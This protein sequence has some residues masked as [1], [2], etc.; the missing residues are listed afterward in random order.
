[1]KVFPQDFKQVDGIWVPSEGADNIAYTDGK[2][3]EDYLKK[4]IDNASDLSSTSTELQGLIRDWS[5]RYHL[6][7]TRGN[8]FRAL[9]MRP[10]SSILEL[11][12]GCGA[13]T[14]CLGENDVSVTAIEGSHQRAQI[15]KSRCR[16]L[17]NVE[18]V[19]SNFDDLAFENKFDIV[20][21]IGVLE[22]SHMFCRGQDD[23]F[24][25]VLNRAWNHLDDD[26]VLVIAIENQLGIK[27][28]SGCG[29]DHLGDRFCGIE[30]YPDDKGARTF[31]KHELVDLVESCGFVDHELLLP[32]PDY[33]LPS[34]LINAK[35][36]GAK[37]AKH[38]N[39]AG[40]CDQPY[41]DY[42]NPREHL[43]H[44][45]LGLDTMAANGL[46]A[47]HANS[48]LLIASKKTLSEASPIS[49]INWHAK[50]INVTRIPK[51]QTE[52]T[53]QSDGDEFAVF[54][55]GM[56]DS[57]ERSEN[58]VTLVAE[59]K[60]Q[61]VSGGRSLSMELTRSLRRT[62]RDVS[63]YQELIAEWTQY[64]LDSSASSAQLGE[65]P[66]HFVD[67]I[68]QNLIRDK[69]GKLVYIDTEWHWR[70]A[71][72][73]EWVV[74]RGLWVLWGTNKLWMERAF[75]KNSYTFKQFIDLSL[76][77]STLDIVEAQ[78]EILAQLEA[79][80]QSAVFGNEMLPYFK[81]LIEKTFGGEG[82]ATKLTMD[83]AYQKWINNHAVQE[84]DGQLFAERMMLKWKSRPKFH[85]MMLVFPGEETLLANT[86]DSLSQQMYP[87]WQLTVIADT[88]APDALWKQMDGLEWLQ[89]DK[90]GDP[91]N[92]LNEQIEHSDS[93]WV[94]YIEPGSTFEPQ[95]LVQLGDYI[96]IRPHWKL[97]YSDEDVMSKSGLRSDPKFKPDFNL[98]MLRSTPYVGNFCV[99]EKEAFI[100]VAGVLP[101]ITAENYDLTFKV[102]D[103]YGEHSIGHIC[104]VLYHA[105]A[106]PLRNYDA[107]LGMAVVRHHLERN[108][109]SAEVKEGYIP[110][111]TRIAYDF[112]DQ[113]VVSIII[114]NRDKLEYLQ[115]CIESLVDKTDYK[116]YEV[117]I[118]DNNSVDPDTLKYYQM[119]T[120]TYKETIKVISCG[121]TNNFS[122]LCNFGAKN[123]NGEFLL[124]L[125]SDTKM[126]HSEWLSRMMKHVQR[127]DIGVVGAR[128][129]YPETGKILHAGVVLGL[130][131]YAE[132]PF[133]G[134]DFKDPGYMG[135][136]QVDQ[137]YSAVSSVCLLTKRNVFELVNG[138][139]EA[140]FPAYFNGVDLCLKASEAGYKTLWTPY[141]TLVSHGGKG[142]KFVSR[143]VEGKAEELSKINL[144]KSA[145]LEKWGHKLSNDPAYNPNLSL[146]LQSF[147]VE[148]E[149]PLNWDTNFN[150]RQ[151]ILGFPLSGG[152]G[153]Y[154]V[155]QPFNAVSF[156]GLAQCEHYTKSRVNI[157]EVMRM[158]PNVTV[159]QA[160]IDDRQ[161]K[162]LEDLNRY[163][164]DVFRVFTLDDLITII[165]EKSS[166]YKSQK[167]SFPDARARLRKSL[168]LCQ[169]LIVTSQP[170]ADY[171]SDLIDDI[172]VIPNR[173]Q[174]DKWL[175]LPS[176]RGQGDKPRVG[177]VGAQQ[178]QGDLEII[179]DV[180]KETVDEVDWV[181]MG[182]CPEE[183][184]PLV[185]EYH[186]FVSIDEYPAKMASLNL[187]LAIAP[188]E[189]HEF[190]ESKSNLRLLEY[191]VFGWP[192]VCSD[193][194]PYQ[195]YDAPVTRVSNE[196]SAW[197]DAIRSHIRD[198]EASKLAG[199]ELKNWVLANFITEDHLEE[200]LDALTPAGIDLTNDKFLSTMAQ[201]A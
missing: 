87:D 176:Y 44:D 76:E 71:V 147:G 21:L 16:D 51:F 9:S 167:R 11:G 93:D 145:L 101:Y 174:R 82:E 20:T 105:P 27:Y 139:S 59:P 122:S 168:A 2:R 3:A 151:K 32:F 67:C 63:R 23:P 109:I 117:V 192:V 100:Q 128:V 14:R 94:S 159:V 164:P 64:L 155:V 126:L 6:S 39:L 136:A 89:F 150:D 95:T 22:Y 36:C 50:K 43:F 79:Q 157:V 97:I 116:N 5:S 148:V 200:W 62:D 186:E 172:R 142:H 198:P 115:P 38:L 4:S 12:S 61:H 152:S 140:Q 104:D 169:R 65:L 163:T 160:A 28:L 78:M 86:L 112:E 57:E 52:T 107:E 153:D 177:W 18:V 34:T 180:V 138:M 42:V 47:D 83:E 53:L 92:Q 120:S 40:W 191:G 124:F 195:S 184:R 13:I 162:L 48:F 118:V 33:K 81:S 129:V 170:L 188:L 173:L 113:P 114:P 15:S 131:G 74:F 197:L 96:N 199:I 56:V 183:I 45:H 108:K 134:V 30:G 99:V 98:D 103:Q 75:L 26:G 149:M 121:T 171:C 41:E 25:W 72:A 10:G 193:I 60:A 201:S 58:G 77:K 161:I 154:R 166:V 182:M 175:N 8:L 187:D 17:E 88:P 135:R 130:D 189:Q 141:S 91:Y 165:P 85:L 68:P 106:E 35:S 70:E 127:D 31:G 111:T 90:D 194:A 1:M 46:L 132:S 37:L 80:F 146:A 178:H 190:N 73:I 196:K 55:K 185:A 84:I 133:I 125:D 144:E 19:S 7:P 49:P 66:S 137:N 54:K 158:Q 102:Y 181:F 110:G 156:A 24:S 179:L 143:K 69:S 29:E 123:A 119:L